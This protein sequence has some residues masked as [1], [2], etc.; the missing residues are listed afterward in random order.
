MTPLVNNCWSI[1]KQ[2][3]MGPYPPIAP[4]VCSTIPSTSTISLWTRKPDADTIARN[5][6]INNKIKFR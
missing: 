2:M 1:S 4:T 6:N 3:R 5:K